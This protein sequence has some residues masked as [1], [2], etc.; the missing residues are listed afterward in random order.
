LGEELPGWVLVLSAAHVHDLHLADV[1]SLV[2][3]LG[4]VED[5]RLEHVVGVALGLQ[6]ELVLL[7]FEFLLPPLVLGHQL[8]VQGHL[9][10]LVLH[11]LELLFLGLQLDLLLHFEDLALAA[12]L[13]LLPLELVVQLVVAD[14]L[15]VLRLGLLLFVLELLLEE[16]GLLLLFHERRRGGVL[17]P[18]FVHGGLSDER[19][20]VDGLVGVGGD[21]LGFLSAGLPEL[22]LEV[23][24]E[25]SGGD[26]DVLHFAGLEPNTPTRQDLLHLLFHTVSEL[27]SI[28]KNIIESQVC[29]SISDDGYC[30]IFKFVVCIDW[31]LLFEI[32]T[33][34]F[35]ASEWS[36]F[37]SVNAPDQHTSDSNTLHFGRN[38]FSNEINLTDECWELDDLVSRK[39]PCG[40]TYTLLDH[41]TVSNDEHPLVCLCFDPEIHGEF[42]ALLSTVTHDS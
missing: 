23:G 5:L 35:V 11:L 22:G 4:G 9:L 28:L 29:N 40:H 12:E 10:G 15:E 20:L 2:D 30:H 37:F 14:P 36:L 3:V 25:R 8:V 42:E 21:P 7:D 1:Q 32:V 16:L 17:G 33:E 38:L 39:S 18:E 19:L 6:S 41:I 27:A 24:E 26:L 34:S 13:Q 31:H